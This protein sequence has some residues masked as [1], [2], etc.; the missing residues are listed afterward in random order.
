MEPTRSGE[1]LSSDDR[2]DVEG[3]EGP[4][5]ENTEGADNAASVPDQE[6]QKDRQ[7]EPNGPATDGTDGASS[8][9]ID[10]LF[11]LLS[12]PGN[13]YILTYVIRSDGPVPYADLVE[14]VVDEG[15]TPAG[16]TTGE[17]RNRIVARLVHSNL[18]KLHDAGLVDY[19]ATDKTVAATDATE[20]VVPYL[21]L[22][23]EQSLR[24]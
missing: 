10:E 5:V 9:S 24:E 14:Y 7:P 1:R 20:M 15:G 19:D 23:M 16:L 21:E 13:R 12:R 17:F 8:I 22:A 3:A 2:P 11:E 18:P 4:D 6:T